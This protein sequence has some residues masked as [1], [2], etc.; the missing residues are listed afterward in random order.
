MKTKLAVVS[1][2]LVARCRPQKASTAALKMKCF[3]FYAGL[4]VAV[5]CAASGDSQ[6]QSFA[7]LRD[8]FV[9]STNAD[10]V[11]GTIAEYIGSGGVVVIP[12]TINGLRMT[13]IG[14]F[15]FRANTRV[16]SVIIPDG[17]STIGDEAFSAVD[18]PGSSIT[19]VVLGN[20]VTTIGRGAFHFCGKLTSIRIPKCV[21]NIGAMAFGGCF[22][23]TNITVDPENAD[24]SSVDGVLFN[25]NRTELVQYPPGKIADYVVP[26]TVTEIAG[27]ALW[28]CPGLTGIVLPE[29]VTTIKQECFAA[30]Y[31]LSRVEIP[32]SVTNI[33]QFAF[34]S[35]VNLKGVYFHGNAPGHPVYHGY[36]GV[37]I[38]HPFD[39][40]N[41]TVVY[42]L[43]GT[44]GWE[45]TFDGQPTAI[46]N[47]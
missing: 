34:D 19:N 9:I 11:T 1:G 40:K 33:E 18:S 12:E 28:N 30:C 45:R 5:G 2:S 29:G 23:L 26:K 41:M 14:S 42:Y 3:C 35:C 6:N 20:S 47:R 39:G 15:A 22:D 44:H 38:Y 10:G 17:V 16:T 43:P 32:A 24:Y 8:S 4:L 36:H 13:A 27:Y 31:R 25:K 37:D 21:S 46:W 7:V